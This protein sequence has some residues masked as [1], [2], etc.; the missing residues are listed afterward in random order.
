MKGSKYHGQVD[1]EEHG[2]EG[3]TISLDLH[4][5]IPSG[6]IHFK[7]GR[8]TFIKASSGLP[9]DKQGTARAQQ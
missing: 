6:F 4:F 8:N 9:D 3:N 5:L 2:Y 1:E 7:Y